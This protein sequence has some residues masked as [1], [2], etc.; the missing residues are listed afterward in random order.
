MIHASAL[1]SN[2]QSTRTPSCS[3]H[4]IWYLDVKFLIW[5]QGNFMIIC[6]Q[7]DIVSPRSFEANSRIVSDRRDCIEI[8]NLSCNMQYIPRNINRIIGIY[9]MLKLRI[10]F[11]A[12]TGLNVLTQSKPVFGDEVTSTSSRGQWVKNNYITTAKS[13]KTLCIFHGIYCSNVSG[14]C[15]GWDVLT[16]NIWGYVILPQ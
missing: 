12:H 10:I 7:N 9:Y 1:T 11:I 14:S 4:A 5:L 2:M 6:I 15:R 8:N 3:R 13:N 16:Y